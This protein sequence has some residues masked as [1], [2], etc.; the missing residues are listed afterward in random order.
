V[1]GM[2]VHDAEKKKKITD[3][4]FFRRDCI[5]KFSYQAIFLLKGAEEI[6]N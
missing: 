1:V 2:F 6:S 3:K 5:R 4:E